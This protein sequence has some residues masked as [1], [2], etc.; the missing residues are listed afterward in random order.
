MGKGRSLKERCDHFLAVVRFCSEGRR[1]PYGMEIA[2]SSHGF[3]DQV[4]GSRNAQRFI[5]SSPLYL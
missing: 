3:V 2:Q 4:F 1:P 5:R